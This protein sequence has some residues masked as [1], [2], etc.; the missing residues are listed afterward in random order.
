MLFDA[1]LR[2][3]DCKLERDGRQTVMIAENCPTH[4]VIAEKCPAHPDIPILKATELK[5]LP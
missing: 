4:P 3:I 2:E 1:W 5:V